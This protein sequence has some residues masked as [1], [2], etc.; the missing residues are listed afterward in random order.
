MS[1]AS[2][3]SIG[4]IAVTPS[5][6]TAISATKAIRAV[7]V[8]VGGNISALMSDGT[9]ATFIGV[10]AGSILPIRV[11]RINSTSTTATNLVALY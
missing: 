6:V 10:V 9:S 3:P 11:T 5:D 1:T 2:D 7:Y 4:A 8:G